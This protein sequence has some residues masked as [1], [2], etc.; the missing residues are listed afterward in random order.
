MVTCWKHRASFANFHAAPDKNTVKAMRQ[1][2][3]ACK[4]SLMVDKASISSKPKIVQRHIKA[5]QKP[6]TG[7]MDAAI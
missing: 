5:L 3:A 4:T 7:P 1:T 6:V 2:R